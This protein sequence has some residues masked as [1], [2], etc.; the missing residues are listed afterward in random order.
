MINSESVYDYLDQELLVRVSDNREQSQSLLENQDL[1]KGF[2]KVGATATLSFALWNRFLEQQRSRRSLFRMG[3]G[4]M[5]LS[6]V[7]LDVIEVEASNDLV[8][9]GR[10]FLKA[11]GD[12][13]PYS[14]NKDWYPLYQETADLWGIDPMA[15][16]GGFDLFDRIYLELISQG[17]IT[18]LASTAREAVNEKVNEIRALYPTSRPQNRAV[19]A[20]A[21]N[22]PA[23]V[24][25]GLIFPQPAVL[26]GE[27]FP[28]TSIPVTMRLK[29]ILRN[30]QGN[31]AIPLNYA[32]RQ[33]N[34]DGI[35]KRLEEFR[36]SRKP[37]AINGYIGKNP[38]TGEQE[39]EEIA[40]CRIV[41][42]VSSDSKYILVQE[43]SDR[44][45]LNIMQRDN[46]VEVWDPLDDYGQGLTPEIA[47]IKK[48]MIT[49]NPQIF[50]NP[51]IRD[52]RK[53]TDAIINHLAY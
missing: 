27:T 18:G 29:R 35:T 25:A 44:V 22:C 33:I 4:L 39:Q 41:V 16:D 8:V 47:K 42:G 32:G 1:L 53:L 5:T 28:G 50:V 52:N 40:V 21:G 13:Y 2:L 34:P 9:A 24:N 19:V 14:I 45:V 7:A 31:M 17:R 30:A 6:N 26:E 46:V 3:V 38:V 15:V 49:T 11:D 36:Q 48:D 51:S 10:T 20:S 23:D 37:F 43:A 12:K